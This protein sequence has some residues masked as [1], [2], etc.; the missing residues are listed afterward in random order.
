MSKIVNFFLSGNFFVLWLISFTLNIIALLLI[1]FKSGFSGPNV[2]LKFNV[3]AGVLWYGQGANLYA[4]TA[5]GALLNIL[6]FLV[7][8]KTPPR[9][10]FLLYATA[11]T[12]LL[13]Q[14]L[15]LLSLIFLATIN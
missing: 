6:N 1:L 11:Y 5:L 12:N 10:L 14:A 15:L 9:N 3:R 2:A 4:L 13:V 7:F 8:K